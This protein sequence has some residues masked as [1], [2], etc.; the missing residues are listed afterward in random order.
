MSVQ[1]KTWLVKLPCMVFLTLWCGGILL[2]CGRDVSGAP[3]NTTSSLPAVQD[4]QP[5]SDPLPPDRYPPATPIAPD[6]IVSGMDSCPNRQ[7]I[8]DAAVPPTTDTVV[9]ILTDLKAEDLTTRQQVAD[10]AYWPQLQAAPGQNNTTATD[11]SAQAMEERIT[12]P[13]LAQDSPYA[14]LLASA[15]GEDIVENTWWVQVCPGPCEAE[16]LPQSLIG[17]LYLIERDGQWF[18]WATE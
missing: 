6:V 18:V 3:G 15:C 8:E 9:Q 1:H 5:T 16:R 4:V 13:E 14:D 7:G 11:D 10:P 17:H 2:G 12:V